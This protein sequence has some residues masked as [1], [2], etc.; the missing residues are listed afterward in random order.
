MHERRRAR[1]AFPLALYILAG[2]TITVLVLTVFMHTSVGNEAARRVKTQLTVG[3]QPAN[4]LLIANNGR[5]LPANRPLGIGNGGGQADVML[6]LHIDP[7]QEGIWAI[8]IPRDALIAQPNWNDPIPKVKTLFFMGDQ[9]TPPSGPE[10]TMDAVS[11]LIGLH[12][13]GYIAVNFE[14]FE[15]A[16]DFLGGVDVNVRERIYDPRNSGADFYPGPQHMNGAQALAFVRVRQNVAGNAYRIN[17]YQRMD[18]EVH[19]LSQIRAKLLDPKTVAFTLPRFVGYMQRDIAT[20]IPDDR[21]V[22]LG[23][24]MVGVPIVEVSLDSVDDSMLLT[25]A[26]IDRVNAKNELEGASY[27]VLDPASICRRL[28]RFGAHDCSDGLPTP[29]PPDQVSVALYGSKALA[30]KLKQRGYNQVKLLGGVTG[31]AT[32]FYPPADPA[33]GWTIARIISGGGIT[34]EPGSSD[35]H[36]VVVYE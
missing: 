17:D 7:M 31:R 6:V 36:D 22:R 33:D 26:H 9:Q 20:D 23:F 16:I 13:D 24:A 11:A 30:T 5:F 3:G 35:L 28:Q 4:I 25:T 19:V 14:G 27:D 21:L 32:V 18:A 29:N 34:V 10:L 12:L 2:L 8:T 1:R 15:K